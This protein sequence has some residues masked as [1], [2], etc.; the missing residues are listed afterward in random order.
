MMYLAMISPAA[1]SLLSPVACLHS[2]V[3]APRSLPRS[4][5]SLC[6]IPARDEQDYSPSSLRKPGEVADTDG[7][8]KV[9]ALLLDTMGDGLVDS[10]LPLNTLRPGESVDTVADGRKDTLL[11][12]TVGDSQVDDALPLTEALPLQGWAQRVL[13]NPVFEVLSLTSSIAVLVTFALETSAASTY[14]EAAINAEL[15][16]SLFFVVEFA[17]RWWSV[18]CKP[19]YLFS[20]A[21]L[22]DLL[23]ILPL[24][25]ALSSASSFSIL[26][27]DTPL[28]PLRA[29]RALR[30]LR[31]RRLL[32]KEEVG[33]LARLLTG[34]PTYAV[35]ES[36]RVLVRLVF[37]AVS[38]VFV[39]AGVE[40]QAERA[41]NPSLSSYADALYF[42]ITTLTTVGFGDVVPVT[43]LGRFVV[44][45]EMM[46]AVTLIPF[47][48]AA[49]SQALSDEKGLQERARP[50]V[51]ESGERGTAQAGTAGPS[52]V[53]DD[54]LQM[55]AARVPPQRIAMPDA[56]RAVVC[57]GCAL[58]SHELD[59]LFCRRCGRKLEG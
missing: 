32:G 49:L 53:A 45:L 46:A 52:G 7:D 3:L 23:N 12:D 33:R 17:L 59:A 27:V 47:E 56:R 39:S 38:I 11:L 36:R 54:S 10:A 35:P 31:L 40:W 19:R 18:G 55:V 9:D 24:F 44:T 51:D 42:S 30:I 20:P 29:L 15:T 37:S 26:A 50:A 34:D 58:A 2:H 8:G 22:I 28:A 4:L 48:L 1:V 16:F 14:V 6:D 43:G 5:V 41:V 25:V 13:A 57:A 21:M